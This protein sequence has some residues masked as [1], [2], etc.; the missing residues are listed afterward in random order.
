MEPP[1]S[2][3]DIAAKTPV[4]MPISIVTQPVVDETESGRAVDL[5]VDS[6][7]ACWRGETDGAE[8]LRAL[9]GHRREKQL[10]PGRYRSHHGGERES[11]QRNLRCCCLL[12][13]ENR[14]RDRFPS[15]F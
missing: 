2:R 6:G 13:A 14:L 11:K 8:K 3:I 10:I 9:E 4:M 12:A 7:T 5:F 1:A 15:E